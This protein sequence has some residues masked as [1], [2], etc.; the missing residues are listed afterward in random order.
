MISVVRFRSAEQ[1]ELA[2]K[3]VAIRH[4]VFVKGQNVEVWIELEHEDESHHYLL[5]LD[6]TPVAT[7]RWRNTDAGIKL[8]RFATLPEYRNRGFGSRLL[9]EIM[10]DIEGL[11]LKIYLH[12]QIGAVRFYEK[13]GFVQEGEIFYEANIG[14]IGMFFKD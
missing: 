3:A 6:D 7:A 11:R 13:H 10:K 9:E 8:E 12:A 4:E 2:E 5:F 14:H 1:P